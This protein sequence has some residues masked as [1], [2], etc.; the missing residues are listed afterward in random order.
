[1]TAITIELTPKSISRLQEEATARNMSLDRLVTDWLDERLEDNAKFD[2]MPLSPEE[3]AGIERG[4]ADVKAGRVISHEQML[5][6]L[7]SWRD[8]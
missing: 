6:D 3:I 5:A 7:A 2:M 8:E 1:M 4:L